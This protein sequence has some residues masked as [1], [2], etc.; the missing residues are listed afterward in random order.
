VSVYY[1]FRVITAMYF[2]AGDPELAAPVTTGDKLLLLLT[3]LIVLA[4][5]IA[6][7]IVM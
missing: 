4:L 6:P 7:Q 3:C 5:G 2:K 1:Y